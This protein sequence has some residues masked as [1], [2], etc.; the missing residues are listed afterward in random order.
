MFSNVDVA[1]SIATVLS[2]IAAAV[3]VATAFLPEG[4]PSVPPSAVAQSTTRPPQS[5]LRPMVDRRP[6]F[7]VRY[8]LPWTM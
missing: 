4:S 2:L 1:L 8:R 7:P 6:W 5:P 3:L